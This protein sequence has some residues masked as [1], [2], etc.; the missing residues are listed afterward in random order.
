MLSRSALAH[1]TPRSPR[2]LP[3]TG[4]ERRVVKL[5]GVSVGEVP[6]GSE[7]HLATALR[8]GT[9]NEAGLAD[10]GVGAL[11]QRQIARRRGAQQ[12][13]DGAAKAALRHADGG[14]RRSDPRG[15]VLFAEIAARRQGQPSRKP[16]WKSR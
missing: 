8:D 3:A 2:P 9:E 11:H 12:R 1:P 13:S 16:Q 14:Q 15:A 10:V 4:I 7:H 5:I 6:E